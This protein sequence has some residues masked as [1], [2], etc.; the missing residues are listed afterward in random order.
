MVKVCAFWP[1]MFWSCSVFISLLQTPQ[2]FQSA[3]LNWG[4][5]T[6]LFL[7]SSVCTSCPL[8]HRSLVTLHLCTLFTINCFYLLLFWLWLHSFIMILLCGSCVFYVCLRGLECLEHWTKRIV[9]SGII[10]VLWIWIQLV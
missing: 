8:N 2:L 6:L 7:R 9:Q 4:I 5:R 3:T 10:K 1:L